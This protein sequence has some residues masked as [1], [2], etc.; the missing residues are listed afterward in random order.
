MNDSNLIR[1]F[2]NNPFIKILDALIDNIGEDYSKKEIQELAGISKGAFFNHWFKLEELHLVKVTR[3]FGKT[4]LFT[5]NKNNKL[6]KDLL[7]FELRMI[8][9]TSP[10]KAVA[11]V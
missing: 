5:L 3:T 7:K 8:E 1:F 11:V 9:E 10:K 2:G 4:K 6:V